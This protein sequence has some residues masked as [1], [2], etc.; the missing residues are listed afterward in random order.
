MARAWTAALTLGALLALT[1]C[2]G[3]SDGGGTA[4]EAAK[5]PR[6]TA[7]AGPALTVRVPVPEGFDRDRGWQDAVT[8]LPDDATSRPF[9]A[10]AHGEVLALLK[11]QGDAYVLQARDVA[12]GA[13]LFSGAPWRPPKPLD[14][15][16]GGA[17]TPGVETVVRGGK[18]YFALWA[19]GV[20]GEDG[21]SK[22]KEVV[23]VALYPADTTGESAAPAREADVPVD[24]GSSEA[25]VRDGG[26]GLLV[27]TAKGDSASLDVATG[28]VTA[29]PTTL[30]LADTCEQIGC[31]DSTVRALAPEGPVIA[32]STG[33]FGIPGGWESSRFAPPGA[34]TEG[35]EKYKARA[36]TSVSGHLVASW[37]AE[38]GADEVSP[39]TVWSVHAAATGEVEASVRCEEGPTDDSPA[40]LSPDGRYLTAGP[41]AF[42]L[43]KGTGHCFA[44]SDDQRGVTLLSVGDDGTAYGL[45]ETDDGTAGATVAVPLGT[46]RAE[47]LADGV[48]PPVL[49]LGEA[50]VFSPPADGPGVLF[51]V[52][53]RG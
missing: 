20:R 2:G 23:A 21:L 49:S 14:L 34:D 43:E 42:D 19:H 12:G 40:A 15:Y 24:S 36:Q 41:L 53:R 7:S 27:T 31:V 16:S 25:R 52:L 39:G 48:Q 44:E 46:G 13:L 17:E 8:W 9:A 50:G 3:D 1:G 22:G 5:E 18:E 30:E 32:Q 45:V 47:P 11:K 33:G 6:T 4:G 37:T 51:T 10:A 38:L 29:Y 35:F 28:A 26:D